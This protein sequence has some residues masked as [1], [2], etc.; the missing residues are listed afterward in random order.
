METIFCQCRGA[1]VI[2]DGSAPFFS[3]GSAP[4]IPH[5]KCPPLLLNCSTWKVETQNVGRCL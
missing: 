3:A 1:E 5:Q 4:S 2:Y